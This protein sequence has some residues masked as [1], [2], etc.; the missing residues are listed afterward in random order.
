MRELLT[1]WRRGIRQGWLCLFVAF[2]GA[3]SG[4]G[5]ELSEEQFIAI[6]LRD[7][8]ALHY[9]PLLDAP[10]D[11]LVKLYRGAERVDELIGLYK[12]HVEQFPQDAGAKT[13]LIRL[14]RRVDRA[15]ADEM[16]ATAVPLHP[17]FA[18]L[19][20]VLFRFL[21][22]R[23]DARATEALSRAIDLETNPARR[24]EWL[25]QLLQ[26]SEGA[27]A[28]ALAD[29]QFNKLLALEN[30]SVES[31]LALARLMQRYQFWDLSIAA[32]NKA[33][34]ARPDPEAEVE[35]D[36]M[37][38]TAQSQLGNRADA[39]R[40]LDALLKRLSAD[41]WRRREIKSMRVGALATDEE[42][43][44]MLATLEAAY[45]KNPK[46]ESSVLDYV[47]LLVASEKQSEAVKVAL[48]ALLASPNSRLIESRALEMLEASPDPAIYADFL[49]QRLEVSPNRSDLRFRLVKV[50][51]ALGRDADAGQDFKTLVA[52]LDPG[53]VSAR[54]LELQRY[55][56]SIDRIDAAAPYLENYV[57]NHPARLDVARELAEIY[58]DGNA[59]AAI[60]AL[61]RTLNAA[62]A[63]AAEVIDLAEFLVSRDYL[64]PAN[65]LVTAKLAVEPKQFDL[66]LLL[67]GILGKMGDTSGA[68]QQIA[69][70]RELA[71]T[72]PRYA[73]WLEVAVAAHRRLETLT[74]FFDSEQNR[75]SFAEGEWPEDR[76][77][78]FL[79]L[80]EVGK[81]QL[82]NDRVARGIR[83]R[84][85]QPGIS[86][87]LR[88]RLRNFL[89]GVLENVPEA[90]GE[91]EEQLKLLATE[92][93]ANRLE[94]DLRRALVYH[95]SQRV[96]LAQKLVAG[97]DL[98]EITSAPLLRDAVDILIEY[99]FLKEAESALSAINRLEPRDLLSWERRLLVLVT[100]RQET[101]FRSVIRSLRSG[102]AGITLRELSNLSLDEH[103]SGSYWRSISSLMASGEVQLEE[104]LP[105]L[106]SAEREDL[107]TGSRL[108]AEWTRALVL[109]RLG[110]D[111]EATEAIARFREHAGVQKISAVNFPDGL[112]LSV[113]AASDFLKPR[114][115]SESSEAV[116]TATF[117]L[118]Q[119]ELRWAFELPGDSRIVFVGRAGTAVVVFDDGGTVHVVDTV[120]GKLA[121]RETYG[122]RAGEKSRGRPAAFDEVPVPGYLSRS[123]DEEEKSGKAARSFSLAAD[124]F[125][126]VRDDE[127]C[128]FAVADGSLLW[129]APMTAPAA[130]E[131]FVASGASLPSISFVV[132][133]NQAVVF[134][135]S[136]QVLTC[137]ETDSGKLI[138]TTK[139]GE[140]IEGASNGM[141][142]LNTGLTLREGHVFVYGQE[143]AILDAASGN[144]VWSFS[145]EESA[146]FPLVLREVRE[147]AAATEVASLNAAVIPKAAA[148]PAADAVGGAV[149]IEPGLY[150]FQARGAV[151]ALNPSAFLSAPS[152][153]VGPGVFWAKE[154]LRSEDA[155]HAIISEGYLMLMQSGK[156]RRISTRLPL[157]SRE[158]PAGGSFV[159]QSGN[160]A[161]F[162]DGE[163]LH[164]VDFYRERASRLDIRDLG[165]P[166]SVRGT[167]V[168]NQL[169]VR[170]NRLLKLINARTG[171]VIGQGNLPV[172]LIEYLKHSAAD[173]APAV[174]VR[175][176]WQGRIYREGH[177][178]PG[179]CFPVTDLVSGNRYFTTF[180][181]H[182][183]VCLETPAPAAAAAVIP[184]APVATGAPAPAA[185]VSPTN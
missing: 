162:L 51:Y 44:S 55:L 185:T 13:V 180:G 184:V 71:D 121:W 139:V 88:M 12:S 112:V 159:G 52:G 171:Q 68:D 41:H 178:Y 5:Q 63:E 160:H 77:E 69:L 156:V 6:S 56:R 79:I 25:E 24:N 7:R 97:I 46:N 106:A 143:S 144:V 70:S 62:E 23:G 89:V 151:G 36:L 120:T 58:A 167:V 76:I 107:T 74:G 42:R 16:V 98:T 174:P 125:F 130:A 65:V 114:P 181:N 50:Y 84:L 38:A 83:E 173:E 30:Q 158:L 116:A 133:G 80:C 2:A 176:V 81:Q 57:R 146:I 10:L 177:G 150:D 8:T 33:K 59:R 35:L 149:F 15:G 113:D 53:E 122:E 92:D 142:S 152:S 54:L 22:E 96:D 19:Q 172:D 28:R 147:E 165:D 138:W 170:G 166:A 115:P 179:Y 67:V 1:N 43:G 31:L 141:F 61:V 132:E 87:Q 75:F 32:L 37:L 47:D 34:A 105:L 137:F 124:R 39:G 183:L 117:L 128:A 126:L 148:T 155:S 21:E 175:A 164:H 110:R 108:W 161:W 73:R 95:R 169:V 20:F 64:Q 140:D 102:D 45:K 103:L 78:K 82:F 145:G 119:P 136:T 3:S 91:V 99:G 131:A 17:D 123:L 157:A 129:S 14:L 109:T 18:P 104:V 134:V 11:S 153:L 86:A 27:S 93:P 118:D 94:Y 40:M 90:A 168:G 60:D 135:P 154:R 100:L 29:L 85:A 111:A 101:I 182:T 49:E 26:L 9:D 4:H 72:S 48:A 66:G 163:F 127:F